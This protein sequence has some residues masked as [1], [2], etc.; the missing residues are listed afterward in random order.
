[1]QRRIFM[2]SPELFISRARAKRYRGGGGGGGGNGNGNGND[3]DDGCVAVRARGEYAGRS[4]TASRL[5]E[6]KMKRRMKERQG[7]GAGPSGEAKTR[8]ETADCR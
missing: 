5:V 7:G 8:N 4:A 2:S 1:M 3:D 6:D